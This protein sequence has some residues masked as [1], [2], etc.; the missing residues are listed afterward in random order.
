MSGF[1]QLAFYFGYTAMFC[2]GLALVCGAVGYWAAALFVRT[3][4][5]W[6]PGRGGWEGEGPLAISLPA[7]IPA[8]GK[9]LRASECRA[10][11]QRFLLLSSC[12]GP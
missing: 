1:F 6:G 8:A 9:S 3:I 4:Y 2:L 10:R 7:L 11:V 12:A 5:R